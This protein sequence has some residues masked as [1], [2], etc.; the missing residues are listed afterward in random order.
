MAQKAGH[1]YRWVLTLGAALA[2]AASCT[3]SPKV[4]P[5]IPARPGAVQP[6]AGGSTVDE[7]EACER[8]RDAEEAARTRLQCSPLE[9]AACPFYVRPAGTGCWEYSEESISACENAIGEYDACGDFD[10]IPCVLSASET[11]A[12]C[13]APPVGEGGTTGS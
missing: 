3:E 11:D 9:R 2:A 5:Y 13:P 7:D 4:E 8:V 1:R 12:S 10:E 6:P